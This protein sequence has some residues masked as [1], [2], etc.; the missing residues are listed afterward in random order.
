[1]A[2]DGMSFTVY[3][4]EKGEK[5]MEV[6]AERGSENSLHMGNFLKCVRSRNYQELNAEVEIGVTSAV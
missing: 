3:K 2:V 5:A 1:M 6:Q 4:G